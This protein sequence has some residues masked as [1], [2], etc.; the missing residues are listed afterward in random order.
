MLF[1]RLTVALFPFVIVQLEQKVT[2]HALPEFLKLTAEHN[3]FLQLS[4][5]TKITLRDFY[6]YLV[7][8]V[9]KDYNTSTDKDADTAHKPSEMDSQL[10]GA[11]RLSRETEGGIA[12]RKTLD[13]LFFLSSFSISSSAS[14]F[15]SSSSPPL[16]FSLFS[17][18]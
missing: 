3:A 12:T 17:S 13:F 16:V 18:S 7:I 5:T 4:G 8:T 15:S 2:T 11:P 9:L 6:G 10:H 14:S 1:Y